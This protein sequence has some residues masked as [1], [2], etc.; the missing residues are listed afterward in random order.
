MFGLTAVPDGEIVPRRSPL[1]GHLVNRARHIPRCRSFQRKWLWEI[2]KKAGRVEVLIFFIT[3]GVEYVLEFTSSKALKHVET[4]FFG[5]EH[6]MFRC[7]EQGCRLV[8][9]RACR[10]Q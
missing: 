4:L 5:K 8:V 3:E 2:P 1:K 9:S 6:E 7:S 10:F